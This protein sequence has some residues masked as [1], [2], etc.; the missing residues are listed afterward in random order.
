MLLLGPTLKS[1]GLLLLLAD[2][3]D[4]CQASFESALL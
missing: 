4:L 3:K 1:A 2:S